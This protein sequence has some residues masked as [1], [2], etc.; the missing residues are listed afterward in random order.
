MATKKH[1]PLPDSLRHLRPFANA[2]AKRPPEEL[3]E[4]VDATRLEAAL[5]KRVRGLD[6]ESADA[7]IA[8]DRESLGRWLRDQPDHPAHWIM[9]FLLSLDLGA[10]LTRPAN[11][12]SRGPTFEFQAPVSWTVKAVWHRLDLKAGKIIGSIMAHDEATH[13]RLQ[14]N[15]EWAMKNQRPGVVTTTEVTDVS[16]GPCRGKKYVY[17]MTAPRTHDAGR[18]PLGGAG[19]VRLYRARHDD[20][21]PV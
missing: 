16:F 14:Q 4:D 8:T 18:L 2:L 7:L 5:R 11:P 10:H 3:N 19:R 1:K 9:G 13:R 6:A 15:H 20:R 12:L 21:R 17:R